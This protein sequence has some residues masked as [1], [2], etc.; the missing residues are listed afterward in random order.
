MSPVNSVWGNHNTSRTLTTF[1]LD[2][3]CAQWLEEGKVWSAILSNLLTSANSVHPNP[4]GFSFRED[5]DF[6]GTH[7]FSVRGTSL[8]ATVRLAMGPSAT[9]ATVYVAT[10]W[11]LSPHHKAAV[12]SAKLELLGKDLNSLVR[13]GYGQYEPSNMDQEKKHDEDLNNLIHMYMQ[14][15][16]EPSRDKVEENND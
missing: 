10:S 8:R 13:V 4:S 16:C 2:R 14:G 15:Q 1:Q 12:E 3:I 7:G 9:H 6:D 5:I 11:E